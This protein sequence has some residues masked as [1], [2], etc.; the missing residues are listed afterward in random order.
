VTPTAGQSAPVAA[1]LFCRI[2]AGEIPADIVD[3]DD[4]VVAFRDINPKAPTHV[5][6]IPREHIA[7]AGDI[8]ARHAPLLAGMFGMANRVAA[9]D[10]VD[11]TGYRLV[12]NVGRDAGQSVDHLHLH[13]LGGRRLDWPPG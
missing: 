3:S 1:C 2:V 12:L 9:A 10:G 8:A 5:L 13:V 11:G 7:S 6:V 4:A